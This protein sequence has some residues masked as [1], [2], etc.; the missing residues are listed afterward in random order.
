[1]IASFMANIALNDLICSAVGTGGGDVVS[2]F[3]AI[4][5]LRWLVVGFMVEILLRIWRWIRLPVPMIVVVVM[6]LI[7][8]FAPA[9]MSSVATPLVVALVS[10]NP[11]KSTLLPLVSILARVQTVSFKL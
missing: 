10:T 5:S 8:T 11:R 3:L 9:P 7:V 4:R 2:R 1:M 6:G